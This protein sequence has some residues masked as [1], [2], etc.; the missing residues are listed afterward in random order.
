M[1]RVRKTKGP[2]HLEDQ[3]W[4]SLVEQKALVGH[5]GLA[6]RNQRK[7]MLVSYPPHTPTVQPVPLEEDQEREGAT[8]V[9]PELKET[10]LELEVLIVPSVLGSRVCRKM[11]LPQ[12]RSARLRIHPLGKTRPPP[13]TLPLG[14]R[15][16]AAIAVANSAA[17]SPEETR[18]PSRPKMS[19]LRTSTRTRGSSRTI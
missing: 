4:R 9:D 8:G 15:G 19:R 10:H 16:H 14:R 5:V 17:S 12:M 1:G 2:V 11:G 18:R 3:V 6:P 7:G 13:P